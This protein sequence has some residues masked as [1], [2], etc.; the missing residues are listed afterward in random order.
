MVWSWLVRVDAVIIM[1][2]VKWMRYVCVCDRYNRLTCVP[3]S[4]SN[5]ANM[6]EFN[7]EGNNISQLPVCLLTYILDSPVSWSVKKN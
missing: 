1:I 2:E 4:L 7:V 3:E 6:D 5:C